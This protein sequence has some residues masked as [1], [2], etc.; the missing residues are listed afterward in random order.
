MEYKVLLL[1]AIVTQWLKMAKRVQV[2]ISI[3]LR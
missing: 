2:K 3:K 1:A